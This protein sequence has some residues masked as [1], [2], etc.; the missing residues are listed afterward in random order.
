MQHVAFPD[1]LLSLNNMHLR[2]LLV[3]SWL[4]SH[5]FLALNHIALSGW[6]TADLAIHLLKTYLGHFQA[7]AAMNKATIHICP[8]FVWT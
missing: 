1:W 6:A 7:L 8:V 4:D 2:F 5:F 3:F